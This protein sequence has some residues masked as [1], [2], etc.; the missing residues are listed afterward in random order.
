MQKNGPHH[1][2]LAFS[3]ELAFKRHARVLS[4]SARTG[5]LGWLPVPARLCRPTLPPPPGARI[6]GARPQHRRL[7]PAVTD[8][9]TAVYRSCRSMR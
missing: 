6:L 2:A 1:W 5:L 7:A 8:N 4:P 9:A 3:Q